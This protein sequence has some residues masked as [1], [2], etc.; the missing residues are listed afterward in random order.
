MT[1]IGPEHAATPAAEV[2]IDEDLL[3]R[4]LTEQH[5]DLAGEA[6]VFVDSGWD[7][8]TYRVGDSLAA[9]LPRRKIAA[10]LLANEQRWL[11]ELAPRLPLPIPAPVRV[12]RASDAFPFPW[13][14]VP[15]L[16]G[17]TA[18]LAEPG[19][20][21]GRALAAFLRALHLPAPNDAPTNPF[22]GVP[23]AERQSAVEER[24]ARRRALIGPALLELWVGAVDV[25]VDAPPTWLHGDLHARNVL[26][27]DARLAGVIDWGD[28]CGGDPATDLASVWM[29][30]PWK[31]ARAEAL[32]AYGASAATELR[33]RGWAFLWGVMLLDSG[34]INHPAHAAMGKAILQRLTEGP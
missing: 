7:N 9:R 29:L 12:G 3:R 1:D 32:A 13:S 21:Q 10:G 24:L 4:L 25:P 22:R 5:P 11:S 23:L 16:D 8:V 17:R 15:W 31:T 19:R 20:D 2:E 33:A 30:L 28:M 27:K 6:I 34:L 18:D 14:V 26:V